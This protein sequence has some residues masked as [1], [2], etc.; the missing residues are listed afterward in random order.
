MT[1]S[2]RDYQ[3][4]DRAA[5]LA[6]F[7][8]N[9]PEWFAPHE[10]EQFEAFLDN[11]PGTYFVM[12]DATGNVAGSGGIE[13]EEDRRTA[14]LTWGMVDPARHRQ[15]L[16]RLQ[17]E[18]RLELL[19]GNARVDRVCI[20]TSNKTAP[21]FERYGFVAQRIIPDGYAKG[22]HRHEMTLRLGV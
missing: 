19:R 2:F 8:A 16:G 5:C 15:G 22:L 21:F 6:I 13:V 11:G 1:Y 3:P 20:D 14:W 17:L 7:A 9:T 12:I 10:R 18:H 4:G